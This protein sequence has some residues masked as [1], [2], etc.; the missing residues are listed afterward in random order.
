MRLTLSLVAAT[1]LLL[2]CAHWPGSPEKS[3]APPAATPPATSA[4]TGATDCA[5]STALPPALAGQF[6]AVDDPALLAKALGQPTKGGLCQGR[7]YQARP[8][9]QVV[10]FRAW[11]STNPGSKLG[12]W[13]ASEI[14]AG[15]VADYRR[16]YEICYQWSPLDMLARCTLKAGTRIVVGN[17]QSA[18]CSPYLTYPV[19][20]R[21]QFYVDDGSALADCTTQD[22]VFGWQ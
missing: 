10:L 8:G 22:G 2:S 18:E 9:T 7:V 19:S 21:Q 14:P 11:N 4:A 3:P 15:K 6:D 16:D 12:K 17:G 5:G 1:S 13:W 20:A